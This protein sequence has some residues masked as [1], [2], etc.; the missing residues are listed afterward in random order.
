MS[1]KVRKYMCMC[2][3]ALLCLTGGACVIWGLA[4]VAVAMYIVCSAMSG[5]YVVMC[6]ATMLGV[7]A[8]T[9]WGVDGMSTYL[10][11]GV[12]YSG[13]MVLRKYMILLGLVMC[14]LK[15]T[16]VLGRD[17]DDRADRKNGRIGGGLL[18]VCAIASAVADMLVYYQKPQMGCIYGAVSAVAFVCIYNIVRPGIVMLRDRLCDE[19]KV[20]AGDSDGDLNQGIVSLMAVSA[21][22]LW[23]MPVD[24]TFHINISLVMGLWMLLYVIYRTGAVYGCGMAVVVGAVT[25]VKLH[26][27]EWFMCIMLAALVML[28]GRALPGRRKWTACAF[29]IVGGI[30]AAVAGGYELVQTGGLDVM[31]ILISVS[32]PVVLFLSI[33]RSLLGSVV[34]ETSLACIQAAATDMNRMTVSKMED[35]ANT[36]RRLDYT[37]AGGDEPG[38]SLSQVGDLVDGFRKQI[39]RIG[40]AREIVDDRLISQIRAMGMDDLRITAMLDKSGRSK[41][42]VSG[43]T[44]GQGLVLSRQVADVLSEYFDR[45]IRVGMNSP[46]LFFDEYRS[47]V[48][49]ENARYK[50]RYHVRR[51]KKCGSPVSGDNFSV[52]EYDDGRL[53][54]MLSDGM[55]SGSLASCESCMMLDTMEELL[56]AGFDPE[57]SIAFANK[58]MTRRNQGRSFT[59]FDMLVIDMY[60]GAMTSY[61]QGAAA[62]YILHPGK[63]G[64]SVKAI[65][66]TTLPIGV[67][68]ETDCDVETGRLEKGDAVIMISDGICDMDEDGSLQRVLR[69]IRIGDSRRM[70]D[71][72]LGRMLGQDSLTPRDDVTVM[73]AV[74]DRSE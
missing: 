59:T 71:E 52:K 43:K 14:L 27:S 44:A 32:A 37:F 26:R 18:A 17:R 31:G 11:P 48:Y 35:M 64:N 9:M 67:L 51:I 57:Y 39:D 12:D 47:A 70:V 19:E 24:I 53:V 54:M 62:T 33:P 2:V 66:S 50:G 29:Y 1:D 13:Y 36:F 7:A 74:I 38:I 60:D 49:E 61:K 42:Y 72:I 22:F 4:P 25:A 46:S 56:E 55:G 3:M 23:V 63:D 16:A 69:E 21:V 45:N 73:A 10:Y 40:E 20:S 34:R 30:L 5:G 65:L 68:D 15:L 41:F 58:C 6:A 28:I 8:G